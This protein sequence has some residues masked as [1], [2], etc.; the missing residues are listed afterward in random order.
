MSSAHITGMYSTIK[1]TAKRLGVWKYLDPDASN[2]EKIP[3]EPRETLE[4]DVSNASTRKTIAA[5]L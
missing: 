5:D 4:L 2:P 1:V 3:E